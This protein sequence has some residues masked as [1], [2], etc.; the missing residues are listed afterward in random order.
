MSGP[1]RE[2]VRGKNNYGSHTWRLPQHAGLVGEGDALTDESPLREGKF[3]FAHTS[4]LTFNRV[5]KGCP[6]PDSY[7]DR[8][9]C[10]VHREAIDES[11]V[12]LR[13]P[14]TKT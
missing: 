12:S 2:G 7:S 5:V 1:A 14:A 3:Y 13:H 6:S 4:R 9:W 11:T 10:P 8:D